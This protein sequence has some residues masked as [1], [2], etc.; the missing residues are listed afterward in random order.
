MNLSAIYNWSSRWLFSTNHKDI[1]TLYFIF[2]AFS[3]VVGT[4]MSI[5]MRMELAQPGS[6][7]LLG[8]YQLWN[9]LMGDMS[10]IG[11]R[12]ERPVFY[13]K[14]EQNIPYFTQRTYEVRP[15]ITGLAQVMSGYDN[16][17]E[18][19]KQK[20]AWDYAYVLSMSSFVGWFKME[21]DIV[22]KTIRVVL[23][24]AGQ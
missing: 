16:S 3:G 24:G 7:I 8:N 13:Q 5:Y 1:G 17:I 23:M 4:M 9:V 2:G 20:I 21:Y 19:V 6:Q 15:G 18:D 22:L 10:L 12:P 14:L 11:P